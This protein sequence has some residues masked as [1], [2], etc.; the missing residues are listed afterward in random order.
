MGLFWGTNFQHGGKFVPQN[1]PTMHFDNRL[2]PVS[3]AT[4]KWQTLGDG[5]LT[6]YDVRAFVLYLMWSGFNPGVNA[7]CELSLLLV[8]FLAPIRF[9]QGTPV[10]PSPQKPKFDQE[11]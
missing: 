4:S 6:D 3:H 1:S 8:L 7:M 2:D 11:R 5:A 9:S 10:F